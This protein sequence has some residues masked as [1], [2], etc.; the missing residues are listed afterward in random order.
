MNHF[1]Y[2]QLQV[3]HRQI[4]LLLL[5]PG[6]DHERISCKLFTASLNDNPEY[7]ALSYAWGDPNVKEPILVNEQDFPVTTNLKAALWHLRLTTRARLLWV[8][9]ICS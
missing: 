5:L 3:P 7:N 1:T 9:A 6:L 8:D 4:R 2:N